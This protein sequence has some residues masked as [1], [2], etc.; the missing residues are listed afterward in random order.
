[1][2][3]F[4]FQAKTSL[5]ILCACNLKKKKSERLKIDICVAVIFYTLQANTACQNKTVLKGL[6]LTILGTILAT[7]KTCVGQN[8]DLRL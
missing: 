5:Q 6:E 2:H 8:S 3:N 1:M 7:T 4:I